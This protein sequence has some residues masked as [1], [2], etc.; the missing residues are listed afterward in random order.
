MSKKYTPSLC[1]CAVGTHTVMDEDK[2]GRYV[3]LSA[4]VAFVKQ[5]MEMHGGLS[6]MYHV[7][8]NEDAESIE[9]IKERALKE[10]LDELLSIQNSP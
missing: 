2:D 4:V 10:L 5:R 7:E 1:K 9:A 6:T 3:E 8:G